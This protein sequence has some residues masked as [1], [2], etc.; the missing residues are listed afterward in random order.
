MPLDLLVLG[1]AL[2][3]GLFGGVHCLAM[4]GG[5]AVAFAAPR[6]GAPLRHALLLNA[7]SSL[8]VALAAGTWKHVAVAVR[9]GDALTPGRLSLYVDGALVSSNPM[10]TLKPGDIASVSGFIG[11]SSS[12]SG[13]QFRGTIKDFRI[14]AKELTASVTSPEKYALPLDYAQTYSG[15]PVKVSGD[16]TVRA[17][18]AGVAGVPALAE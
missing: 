7:G 15:L 3:A 12:A 16:H 10:L 6:D 1:G 5:L 11:R 14:Y 17:V 4:C 8:P 2:L 13:Q 18:D 9:G